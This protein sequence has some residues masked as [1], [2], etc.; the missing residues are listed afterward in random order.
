MRLAS[1]PRF[2]RVNPFTRLLAAFLAAGVALTVPATVTA[3]ALLCI[4]HLEHGSGEHSD[5]G[6]GPGA[7]HGG[8]HHPGG[9]SGVEAPETDPAPLPCF[10]PHPCGPGAAVGVV[11]VTAG[12]LVN[13]SHPPVLQAP[14]WD[15]LPPS[16][17]DP[18][19]VPT[20]PDPPGPSFFR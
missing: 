2:Q 11:P 20:G 8:N 17:L 18:R 10:C 16:F 13:L 7:Q 9:H 19:G 4:H 14:A 6:G 5:G 12:T 3:E 1:R 15:I